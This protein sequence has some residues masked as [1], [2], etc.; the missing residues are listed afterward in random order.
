MSNLSIFH[1]CK[2]MCVSEDIVFRRDK[3]GLDKKHESKSLIQSK[4]NI[5]F[6]LKLVKYLK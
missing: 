1:S 6:K 5:E 3:L 4:S 2:P